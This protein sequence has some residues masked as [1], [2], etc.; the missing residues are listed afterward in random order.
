MVNGPLSVRDQEG[1]VERENF[2][3]GKGTAEGEPVD[4]VRPGATGGSGRSPFR[5][6]EQR[7]AEIERELAGDPTAGRSDPRRDLPD[8]AV[9]PASEIPGPR[10]PAQAQMLSWMLRPVP[11]MES[12]RR[13]YGDVFRVRLGPLKRVAIV[14]NPDAV[15]EI[16]TGDPTIFQLGSTNGIFRPV[17]GATSLFLLDGQEHRRHRRLIAPAFHGHHVQRFTTLIEEATERELARWPIGKSI[18]LQGRMRK[19]TLHVIL[20]VVFDIQEER[21]ERIGALLIRL[22]DRAEQPLAVMPW[23]R[24]EMRGMTPYGSLMETTR[25]LNALLFE[26]IQARRSDPQLEERDDVLSMLARARHD[27]ASFMSDQ[28]IR[29]EVVTLLIAGHETTAT[30]LAWLFDRLLQH[31]RILGRLEEDLESGDGAY[32]DATI[33]ETLRQRPVLP[34]TARKLAEPQRIGE[35]DFEAGWTLM[36][37]IYLLHREPSI[38]PDPDTFRPE[39]FIDDPPETH[40]WIPFGGGVRHCIGSNLSTLIMKTVFA[41]VVQ[42]VDIRAPGGPERIARRNFTLGPKGGCRVV[43]DRFEPRIAPSKQPS[44]VGS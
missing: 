36:P 13:R 28:E 32:L 11:F 4:D 40:N 2:S 6:W 29:D 14:S 25:E 8:S 10:T 27:D 26:E 16:L 17:L 23:F 12:C 37:A 30:A 34:V 44:A 39:R 19:I 1:P 31:P 35:Y 41:T 43:V 42:S 15:R 9:I 21:R 22:L 3:R 20:R 33:R 5:R 7:R 24:Y 38:Y 18:Q